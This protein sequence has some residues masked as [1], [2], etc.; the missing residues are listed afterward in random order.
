MSQANVEA[1]ERWLDAYNRR[2]VDGLISLAD[3]DIEFR[4]LFVAVEP[5]FRG[6]EGIRRYLRE[7]DDAYEYFQ[8][9]P[10]EFID[11]GAAVLWVGR[12]EW[13]G[14]E[15]GAGGALELVPAQWLRDGRVFRIESFRERSVA[16]RAVGLTEEEAL[17][18][19]CP[20]SRVS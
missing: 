14:K 15:S 16:L 1:V 12:F 17:A 7:L 5:V 11:A 4:S 8:V 13:R 19:S 2:D 3:P 9:V 20:P 18:A 6:Y 10:I